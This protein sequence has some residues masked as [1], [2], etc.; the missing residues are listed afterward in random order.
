MTETVLN[1][2]LAELPGSE[3]VKERQKPINRRRAASIDSFL[4]IGGHY[5]EGEIPNAAIYFSYQLLLVIGGAGFLWVESLCQL[6]RYQKH[7]S[8]I[9]GQGE[10]SYNKFDAT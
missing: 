9:D 3:S 4:T 10:I 2:K 8:H 7:K 6:L 1:G 5:T